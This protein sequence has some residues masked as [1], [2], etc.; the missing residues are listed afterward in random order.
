MHFG[1]HKYSVVKENSLRRDNSQN[2]YNARTHINTL[3]LSPDYPLNSDQFCEKKYCYASRILAL[4]K[5][6]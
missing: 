6:N 4:Y 5:C 3:K 1:M 2:K